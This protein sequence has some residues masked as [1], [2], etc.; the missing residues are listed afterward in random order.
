MKKLYVTFDNGLPEGNSMEERKVLS[1]IEPGMDK[2]PA[3]SQKAGSSNPYLTLVNAQHRLE[4]SEIGIGELRPYEDIEGIPVKIEKKTLTAYRKLKQYLSECGISVGICSAFRSVDEQQALWD[5]G[6][7]N[8]DFDIDEFSKRVAL[9]GASEHHTGLA[10]DIL[11]KEGN[12]WPE[13]LSDPVQE[14]EIFSVIHRACPRFGFIL[15]YPQGKETV[16]GYQYEPWHLRYV[17]VRHAV[18]MY[19]SNLTLEEYNTDIQ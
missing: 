10:I 15:R 3:G 8:S 1:P 13:S 4:P 2:A 9:P 11:L 17:G 18:A 14:A 6:I 12:E 7:Q 5:A 19:E 16:T